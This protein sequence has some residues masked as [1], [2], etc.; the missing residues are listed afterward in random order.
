[1]EEENAEI[2]KLREVVER[3]GDVEI[4]KLREVVEREEDLDRITKL[5]LGYLDIKVLTKLC[6][7]LAIINKVNELKKIDKSLRFLNYRLSQ[8]DAKLLSVILGCSVRNAY[9]YE[10]ALKCLEHLFRKKEEPSWR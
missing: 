7:A 8:Y 2:K 9:S 5:H 10:H 1:M 3:E 6:K 4:K